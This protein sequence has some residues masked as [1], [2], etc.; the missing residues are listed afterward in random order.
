MEISEYSDEG[1]L[2][3]GREA[4][5][6]EQW[7]RAADFFSEFVRRVNSRGGSVPASALASYALC[8]GHGGDLRQALEF[9]GRALRA[10]SRNPHV[11]WCQAQLHMLAGARRHAVETIERGLRASSDNFLLLRLRRRLGVRQPTPIPFL[12]RKHAL[13]VR[14]GRWMHRLRG[15]A[16]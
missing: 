16:A 9:C 3:S 5:K 11:Y 15:N 8:L 14:L 2:D 1:L 10:D 6:R 13:N 12:D 4:M 7:S